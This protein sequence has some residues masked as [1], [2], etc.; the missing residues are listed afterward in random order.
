MGKFMQ[1]VAKLI[2]KEIIVTGVLVAVV[3]VKRNLD[4]GRTIFG[5]ERRKTRAYMMRDIVAVG[6]DDYVIE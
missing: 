4:H 6:T 2:V 3:Q 1:G 5:N